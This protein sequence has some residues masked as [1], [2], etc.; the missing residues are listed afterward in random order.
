MEESLPNPD[1]E[2]PESEAIAS[3]K[4][5]A[6]TK[7]M[8]DRLSDQLGAE[9]IGNLIAF[10]G[11]HFESTTHLTRFADLRDLQSLSDRLNIVLLFLATTNLET[12][13]QLRR[14]HAGHYRRLGQYA[15][16][17]VALHQ[18]LIATKPPVPSTPRSP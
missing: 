9:T 8:L 7:A 4:V 13:Q 16:E 17:L 15:D 6:E 11:R 12:G 2:P 1:H 14:I 10:L 18:R 5:S 3:V